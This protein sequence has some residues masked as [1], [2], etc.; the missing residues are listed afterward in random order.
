MAAASLP[1]R[2]QFGLLACRDLH[3]AL[4]LEMQASV[5]GAAT[6]R[7]DTEAYLDQCKEIAE[8]TLTADADRV[9]AEHEASVVGPI[10]VR[11]EKLDSIFPALKRWFGGPIPSG[12]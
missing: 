9:A 10:A 12:A 1:R 2:R 4:R 8:A 5:G 3:A 6:I 7:L 11:L